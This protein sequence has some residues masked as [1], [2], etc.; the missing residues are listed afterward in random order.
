MIWKTWILRL[1]SKTAG[2]VNVHVFAQ[3][4]RV[5]RAPKVQAKEFNQWTLNVLDW[6]WRYYDNNL[7]CL[8]FWTVGSRWMHGDASQRDFCIVS[9]FASDFLVVL[10]GL[11]SSEEISCWACLSEW[12]WKNG[13]NTRQ[14]TYA[15]CFLPWKVSGGAHNEVKAEHKDFHCF[16]W[17]VSAV[18]ESER[19]RYLNVPKAY[20]NMQEQATLSVLST[21]WL[22]PVW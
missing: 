16:E 18:N 3:I 9:V 20:R 14:T 17:K 5:L 12:N 13:R 10:Q 19:S 1:P 7:L 22:H 8:C 2:G 4:L 6:I 11:G 21:T 15:L